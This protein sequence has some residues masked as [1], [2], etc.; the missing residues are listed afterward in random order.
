M[1]EK[2]KKELRKIQ[3][4]VLDTIPVYEMM[5]SKTQD[6]RT[7]DTFRKI[8]EDKRKHAAMLEQILGEPGKTT[9]GDKRF[10]GGMRLILGQK[11]TLKMMAQS[12]YDA[13]KD[14]E[15][16]LKN[17]PRLKRIVQDE[18]RHGDSLVRLKNRKVSKK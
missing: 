16:Q 7:Q 13:A 17:Y 2:E 12:E 14:H 18:R 6:I 11:G 4:Y 15:K 8:I 9:E 3:S 10:V 5:I 1:E